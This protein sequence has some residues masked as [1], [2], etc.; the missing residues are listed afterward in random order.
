M[1]A[2]LDTNFIISC[3]KR[4]IDVLDE[5][6]AL[7]FIPVVPREVL[8]ELKDLRVKVPHG[9][10]VAIQFA[11]Q[12]F[13]SAKVKKTRLGGKSVD[14]GLIMKGK[15]GLYIATLDSA[16]KRV[17]PNRIVIASAQNALAIERA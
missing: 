13:S 5:I 11:L 4:R 15:Q 12:R 7:G 6:A 8:E 3:F 10:R 9:D 16:I 1:E 17:V 2:L 14:E